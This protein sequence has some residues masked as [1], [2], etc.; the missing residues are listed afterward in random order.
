MAAQ[1]AAARLPFTAAAH[2]YREKFFTKSSITLSSAAQDVSPAG[3]AVKSYGYLRA[4]RMLLTASVAGT[5]GNLAAD[6]VANFF[7]QVS[8]T[9]PNGEEMFGGPTWSGFHTI[10]AAKHAAWKLA[11]DPA[12]WP[13]FANSATSPVIN[14]PIVFEMNA[15]YGLGSLPNQDFSAPWK[16]QLTANTST[17][18]WQTAPTT[19]PTLQVD[20][21]MDCWTVPSPRNPLN[22]QVEQEVAPPLLGSLNKWTMQTYVLS[23]T[24]AQNILL[25][26]KGNA[27]RNLG[28]IVLSSTP[29]RIAITNLVSGNSPFSIRWDGTVIR[30]NDDVRLVLDDEYQTRGGAASS[31]PTTADT[32]VIF[33][34]MA[35]L[36]GVDTQGVPEGFGMNA[37][38]GTVQSST[39]EFDTTTG[40]SAA[41]LQVLTNDVQFVNLA[42][43]PYAFAYAGYLQAPAQPIARP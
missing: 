27:I 16:L 21:F 2:R 17:A 26:R 42:G 4:L 36:A 18:F 19:A 41:S 29:A 38:W 10:Q 1:Q 37:F 13:S 12:T 32:G 24:S 22:P 15:E 30:S 39:L 34:Q 8:V 9:Q 31:T 20:V 7:Q 14:L 23:A 3:G 28:F 5:G 6:G 43:N 40:G 11:N 25:Q 35:D 33:F